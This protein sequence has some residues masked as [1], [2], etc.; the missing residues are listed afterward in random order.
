MQVLNL[1]KMKEYYSRLFPIR[2]SPF[3]AFVGASAIQIPE[4][5]TRK[6]RRLIAFR[7]KMPQ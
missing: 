7:E 1:G 3:F 2:L 5:L 6:S 4:L